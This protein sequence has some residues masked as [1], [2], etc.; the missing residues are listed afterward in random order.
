[1]SKH[2]PIRGLSALSLALGFTVMSGC[3]TGAEIGDSAIRFASVGQVQATP[4]SDVLNAKDCRAALSAVY[5]F[6]REARG[7]RHGVFTVQ[8]YD[9][10]GDTIVANVALNN[11][12]P[13]PM[14]CFAETEA[15]R[16]GV[17]VA[18]TGSGFFEYSYSE[19]AVLDCLQAK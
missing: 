11:Y 15:E 16:V 9:C 14:Y 5:G 4:F 8:S 3:S 13:N 1:M 6:P 12:T 18:P 2:L 17:W 10:K 7:M 19:Q